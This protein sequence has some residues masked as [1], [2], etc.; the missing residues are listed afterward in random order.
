MGNC[1]LDVRN[2]PIMAVG[3]MLIIHRNVL[4]SLQASLMQAPG[5]SIAAEI[6][7]YR[8]RAKSMSLGMM[9]QTFTTW[10][11]TFIVPYM[12]NVDSGNLGART[13]L[14]F[15]GVSVL[16]IWGAW[17]IV[18]DTTGL[19]TEDID[20]LYEAKVPARQF[21]KHH[22]ALHFEGAELTGTA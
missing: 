18:P 9:A 15:A 1:Y 6:S 19:S 10:L 2:A 4:I 20:G 3:A 21:A 11:V 5:W 13:G 12:Y 22:Q 7:S 14:V 8:L 17:S 16:L